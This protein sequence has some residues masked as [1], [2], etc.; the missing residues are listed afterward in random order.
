[1]ISTGFF[2]H[3][4]PFLYA[5]NSTIEPYEHTVLTKSELTTTH[6]ERNLKDQKFVNL[7]YNT[8]VRWADGTNVLLTKSLI[9]QVLFCFH[10]SFQNS[11]QKPFQ[12]IFFIFL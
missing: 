12:F 11:L 8:L 1:M 10:K 6:G 9:F 5:E 3:L 2:Y 4:F 7:Q